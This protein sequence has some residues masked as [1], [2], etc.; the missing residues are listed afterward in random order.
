MP[1]INAHAHLLPYPEEFPRFM[2]EK[3]ILWID[4][5][6]KYMH[7]KNWRRPIDHDSFFLDA[8]L[9]WLE[10]HHIDHEVLITLSQLYCNGMDQQITADVIRFQNDY[11]LKIQEQYPKKFTAGFVVQAAWLDDALREMER[12]HHAGLRLLCLPTHFLAQSGEWRSIIHET[13]E[14][15]FQYADELGLSL[16]IHPYDGQKFIHL[17]DRFWRFHL[18]WMLAQCADCYHFFSL[19]DY[20]DKYPNLRTCFAHGNQMSMVN[21]GRRIQG[22]KGRPDLFAETKNPENILQATNVYHDTLVHDPLSLGILVNRVPSTQVVFGIDNPYPLGEMD[23]VEGSY[24]GRVLK[25]AVEKGLIDPDT[26]K[27]IQCENVLRWLDKDKSE[28]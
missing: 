19:R 24:P 6:R 10:E 17:E 28:L 4:K 23:S 7:Q 18:V 16:E 27:M 12:C 21:I 1:T 15:I 13:A 3:E 14:P 2:R 5:E 20:D 11:H 22:F 8:K 25:E 26:R 9:R